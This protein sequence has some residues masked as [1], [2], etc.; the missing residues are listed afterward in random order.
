VCTPEVLDIDWDKV[1]PHEKVFH[2]MIPAY[3]AFADLKLRVDLK[4]FHQITSM[5]IF[6]N[7]YI[8]DSNGKSLILRPDASPLPIYHMLE[9]VSNLPE[10]EYNY[11]NTSTWRV[12][13][14]TQQS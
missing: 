5:P 7:K 2:L 8:T 4:H 6:E 12:K 13:L 10:G 3:K 1:I 14:K 11:Q 9:P